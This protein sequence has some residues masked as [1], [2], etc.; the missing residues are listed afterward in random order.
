[1][2]EPTFRGGYA[3]NKNVCGCRLRQLP[4]G[5][6]PRGG[7]DTGGAF[8]LRPRERCPGR[9]RCGGRRE[10]EG[11]GRR[12]PWEG[13]Q[14]VTPRKR[15]EGDHGDF[16][17]PGHIPVPPVN[18]ER[19]DPWRTGWNVTPQLLS[20]TVTGRER[21]GES[22]E[23]TLK[24]FWCLLCLHGCVFSFFIILDFSLEQEGTGASPAHSPPA[25]WA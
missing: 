9:E 2:H 20:R 7:T 24:G 12:F 16:T 17:G 6:R 23:V 10:E 13:S 1:M 3:P 8:P 25:T 15:C 11:A 5:V 22:C 18:Q 19:T 14:A 4:T 21:Y